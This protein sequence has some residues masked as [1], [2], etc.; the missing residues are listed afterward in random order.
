MTA[1][2]FIE[3]GFVFTGASSTEYFPAFAFAAASAFANKIA[4]A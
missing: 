4:F 1:A 2:Y 3:A